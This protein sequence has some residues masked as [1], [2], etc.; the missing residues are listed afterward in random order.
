MFSPFGWFSAITCIALQMALFYKL[1]KPKSLKYLMLFLCSAYIASIAVRNHPVLYWDVLWTGR[2]IGMCWFLWSVGDIC[3]LDRNCS[4][5]WRVPVFGNVIMFF[6]YEP[7][8]PW[9]TV[10]EMEIFIGFG[11]SVAMLMVLLN[12]VFVGSDSPMFHSLAGLGSFLSLE[13]SSALLEIRYP[14][15]IYPLIA[16]ILGLTV[17]VSILALRGGSGGVRSPVLS[18]RL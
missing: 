14:H 2:M 6:W 5:F 3:N 13:I 9:T 18:P 12:L 15:S 7:Y 4:W 16:S 17:W 10:E 11:F 8:S 1:S